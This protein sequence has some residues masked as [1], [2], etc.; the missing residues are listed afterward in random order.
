MKISRSYLAAF[1]LVAATVAVGAF[2]YW[3]LPDG[4]MIAVRYNMLGHPIGAAPKG[5]ALA[6]VPAVSIL[7]ISVLAL[8]SRAPF[9]QERLARS[10]GPFGIL[11]MGVAAVL[12]T[13]EAAMGAK[14]IDPRFDVLRTVFLAVAVMLIVVGNVLG[15]IR[16]NSL[17]GVRTPWTLGD[18]RVWDKTHRFTGWAMVLGGAALAV[19]DLFA[20]GGAWLIAAMVICTAGPLVLGAAH[21]A[22][23]WRRERQA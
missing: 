16:Q 1:A 6:I 14:A 2:A 20:P 19:I 5:E 11:L 3:R 13:A 4:A 8:V 23:Q 7:V 15:K 9:Y 17:F 18:E 12:F 22:R 21:S 10:R